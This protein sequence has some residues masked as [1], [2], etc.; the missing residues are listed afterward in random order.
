MSVLPLLVPPLL[1]SGLFLP[2]KASAPPPRF[3]LLLSTLA[4]FVL[5]LGGN[6]DA[7]CKQQVPNACATG[8][9]GDDHGDD[10]CGKYDDAD[11]DDDDEDDDDVDG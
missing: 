10:D 5:D 6:H 4:V 11:D 1:L 2:Q 8:D 7:H 9:D 3:R